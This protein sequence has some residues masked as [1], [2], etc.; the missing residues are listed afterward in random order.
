MIQNESL[1][2]WNYGR[3]HALT[4]GRIT[5]L[6]GPVADID[7][8][9]VYRIEGPLQWS[10]SVGPGTA[11]LWRAK[12]DADGITP[13]VYA[14]ADLLASTGPSGQI[15]AMI[16]TFDGDN[17]T[18]DPAHVD[19]TLR[20]LTDPE[21]GTDLAINQALCVTAIVSQVG[22]PKYSTTALPSLPPPPPA[23]IL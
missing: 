14:S 21:A 13:I 11:I 17:A 23:R 9:T 16:N 6:G 18:N 2:V 7:D 8:P 19:I 12:L 4:A 10:R 22:P 3:G 20:D 15:Q 1:P 5:Y